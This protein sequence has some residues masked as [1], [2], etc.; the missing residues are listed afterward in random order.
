MAAG[1]LSWTV[2][3]LPKKLS[4]LIPLSNFRGPPPASHVHS[5][6]KFAYPFFSPTID[7]GAWESYED[8]FAWILKHTEA[9]DRYCYGLDTMIYIHW[10]AGFSF[11]SSQ[12]TINVLRAKAYPAS[13]L[14][15]KT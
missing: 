14:I 10:Q 2:R 6:I 4:E 1:R 12:S 7:R 3:S 8:I 11:F 15:W 9:D 13:R 5:L